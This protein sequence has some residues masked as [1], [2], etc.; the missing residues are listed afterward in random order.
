MI[1]EWHEPHAAT[2]QLSLVYD[3][4]ISHAVSNDVQ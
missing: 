1:V 3:N 4:T 2:I